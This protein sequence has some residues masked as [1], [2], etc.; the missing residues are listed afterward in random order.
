MRLCNGKQVG[1]GRVYMHLLR[2]EKFEEVLFGFDPQPFTGVPMHED[3]ARGRLCLSV[4]CG[5]L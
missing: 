4:A 3:P 1:G 5:P 2:E